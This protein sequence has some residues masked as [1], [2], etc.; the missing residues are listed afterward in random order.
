MLK[1]G[2][3]SRLGICSGTQFNFGVRN[4]RF[5]GGSNLPSGR[6]FS[7]CPENDFNDFGTLRDEMFAYYSGDSG[8]SPMIFDPQVDAWLTDYLISQDFFTKEDSKYP[9]YLFIYVFAKET[10]KR[11]GY[12]LMY[13]IASSLRRT[14][15]HSVLWAALLKPLMLRKRSNMVKYNLFK[16]D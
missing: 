14:L 16:I 7:I 5:A 4:R 9:Y 10:V 8:I 6:Y 12:R 11:F 15:L 1:K 13:F 3:I 2:N